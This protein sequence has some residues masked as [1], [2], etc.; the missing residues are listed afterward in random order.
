MKLTEHAYERA[1]ERLGLSRAAA[2]RLAARAYERGVRADDVGGDAR[3]YLDRIG[4]EHKTTAIVYGEVVYSFGSLP[5][6]TPA[7]VTTFQAPPELK[8][9]FLRAQKRRTT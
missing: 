9:L 3:E 6:G 8:A 4:I 5:D 2:L 7:L 1:K